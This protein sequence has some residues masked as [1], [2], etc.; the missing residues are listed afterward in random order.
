M[1]NSVRSAFIPFLSYIDGLYNHMYCDKK[2]KVSVAAGIVIPSANDASLMHWRWKDTN[3]RATAKETKAEWVTIDKIG[4]QG[5]DGRLPSYYTRYAQ[6]ITPNTEI[7]RLVHNRLN[8]LEEKAIKW[9]P[10]DYINWCADRQMAVLQS[11]WELG[12][13]SIDSCNSLRVEVIKTL[14]SNAKICEETH[15]NKSR[16]ITTVPGMVKLK[17][18]RFQ[19]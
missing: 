19:H 9:L 6:L 2:R 1:H 12:V 11:V 5:P 16:L 7:Y 15:T 13:V 14:L 3:K 10:R 4:Q 18:E 8:I 17:H